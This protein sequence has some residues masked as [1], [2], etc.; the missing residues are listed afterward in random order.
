MKYICLILMFVGFDWYCWQV[1]FQW[2]SE[3]SQ[4]YL[5]VFLCLDLVI[6]LGISL[7]VNDIEV[8][9]VFVGLVG[10]LVVYDFE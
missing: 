2:C 6:V 7:L 10:F 3:E 8:R 5:F 4:E 1:K 9:L